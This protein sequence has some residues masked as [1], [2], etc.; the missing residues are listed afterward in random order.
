MRK[1]VEDHLV[2]APKS[3][4]KLIPL[5]EVTIWLKPT[6]LQTELIRLFEE[7]LVIDQ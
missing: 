1:F 2:T 6:N 5:Q 3:L 4:L 7:N